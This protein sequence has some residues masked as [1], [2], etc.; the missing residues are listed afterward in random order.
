MGSDAGFSWADG[1]SHN[2][3]AFRPAFIQLEFMMAF[4]PQVISRSI[5][6]TCLQGLGLRLSKAIVQCKR[7]VDQ[8]PRDF[9]GTGILPI[10][11]S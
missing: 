11:E 1:G 9:R 3:D 7:S 10:E 8:K 6:G 2:T 4:H 5:F